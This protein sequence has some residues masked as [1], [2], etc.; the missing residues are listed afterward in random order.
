MTA[1][2]PVIYSFWYNGIRPVL[3]VRNRGVLCCPRGPFVLR[4]YILRNPYLDF[5]KSDVCGVYA[6]AGDLYDQ[7]TER[8]VFYSSREI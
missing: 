1:F 7:D 4:R 8:E 3:A 5:K 6:T 2:E